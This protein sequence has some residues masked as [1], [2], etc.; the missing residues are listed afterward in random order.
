MPNRIY[1]PGHSVQLLHSG[2]EY[3]SVLENKINE[4]QKLIHLQVYILENDT[5]GNKIIS[6]LSNAV[7]RGVQ[8]FLMVDGFG[9]YSLQREY[10]KSIESKGIAFRYFSKLPFTGITLNGR[11]LHHKVCVVDSK[12]AIVG[13]I[14]IADKYSGYNDKNAWLDYAILVNGGVANQLNIVCNQIWEKKFVKKIVELADTSSDINPVLVRVSRND[15]FRGKNEI[16]SSY[17]NVLKAAKSEI[18]IVASYF[19]PSPRLLK[20]LK[21]A[22]ANKRQVK[23]I[24]TRNSDV[25]MM[26]QAINYLY[27]VLLKSGIQIFEYKEAILHAKVCVVDREWATI[28]SHNLNKLSEFLSVEL[29]LELNDTSFAKSFAEELDQLIVDKCEEIKIEDHQFKQTKLTQLINKFSFFIM[30]V[31]LQILFYL[32]KSEHDKRRRKRRKV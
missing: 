14:N 22:A 19:T 23:I 27:S 29:N 8:V 13:G 7:S 2:D 17:K 6:A 5:T 4:A 16:S 25:F 21:N 28:G 12:I 20:I 1:L 10:I 3:F 24:L 9:S 18:I 11:R 26:K 15:W 31:S 32:N 30:T